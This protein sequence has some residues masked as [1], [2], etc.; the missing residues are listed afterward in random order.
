MQSRCSIDKQCKK[1]MKYEKIA[2]IQG[3]PRKQSVYFAKA[4]QNI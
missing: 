3:I 1:Y 2:E 4:L